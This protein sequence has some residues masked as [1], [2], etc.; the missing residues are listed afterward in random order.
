MS[1]V[2]QVLKDLEQ[3][4]ASQA[5][6]D[7]LGVDNLHY[8][9]V[10][11]APAKKSIPWVMLVSALLTLGIGTVGGAYLYSQWVI[12]RTAEV[13]PSIP[14]AQTPAQS[15]PPT[16][17]TDKATIVTPQPVGTASN[18]PVQAP[19]VAKASE[20]AAKPVP[21]PKVEPVKV[22]TAVEKTTANASAPVTKVF[23]TE[24]SESQGP[25]GGMQKREVPLSSEQR[26]ERAYQEGYDAI[27]AHRY[28][29]AE[30]ALSSAL[31]LVPGHIQAR[32][33]LVGVFISQGR[34]IEASEV[35]REG[36]AVAPQHHTFR[37]LYARSL[38]QMKREPQAIEVLSSNMPAAAQDPEHYAILAALFQRQANHT[39]AARTY[40]QILKVNPQMG[41]W[42]V[43]MGISLEA[44]GQQ[45]Q[46]IEAYQQARKTGSLNGDVAR[47]TDNRLLA[48]DAIKY[49]MD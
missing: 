30:T 17:R 38:M 31:A 26:A 10:A 11:H 45:A 3:R 22:K 14:I 13:T 12:K 48:L 9:P 42:W 4:H 36:M 47:Y 49:P 20:Q 2:N 15:P 7:D 19:V 35:L 28:R 33:M 37:K 1:L 46:A 43:G 24:T 27:T 16:D 34:W 23:K 39:A 25:S 40:A 6:A 29:K 18:P 44:L 8:V 41:I 5:Q 32:E 21:A